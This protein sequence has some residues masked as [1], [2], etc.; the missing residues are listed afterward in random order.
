VGPEGS[1]VRVR[2]QVVDPADQPVAFLA[3]HVQEHALMLVL[4]QSARKMGVQAPD[5]S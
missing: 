5:T 3:A 1:L 4:Q 2:G